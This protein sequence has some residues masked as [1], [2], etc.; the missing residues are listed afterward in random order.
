MPGKADVFLQLQNEILSLQGFRQSSC[1]ENDKLG[2]GP[3][4]QSFP[5]AT[6]P[7]QAVHEFFCTSPEETTA[8]SAF[9]TG[10]LSSLMRSGGVALWVSASRKI[11]PPALISLGIKPE[12][13]IFIDL[14]KQREV[15]WV[16]EQ[17]LQCKA[18]AAVACEMQELSFTASRRFQL[19]IEKSSVPL[20][21]L[22]C[23]PKNITTT[24]I[25]RWCIKPLLSQ[26]ED[27]LPGV[28]PPRWQVTLLKVRNGKPGSWEVQWREGRF[29]HPSKLTTINNTLHKKTG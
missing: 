13:L 20:F 17:A 28:G 8:S 5:H 18:L 29:H 24:A 26:N 19:V 10:I 9:I 2:L 4:N 16:V 25:T 27:G 21:V 11:F 12:Q 22:R 14:K 3:I 23:D 15:C 6:F 7:L 1:I